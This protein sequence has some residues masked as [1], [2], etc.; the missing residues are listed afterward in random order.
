[1]NVSFVKYAP[2]TTKETTV[3][4]FKG[5]NEFYATRK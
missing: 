1:M 4:K 2:S 3:E 5:H